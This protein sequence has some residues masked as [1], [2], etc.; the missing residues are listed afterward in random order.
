[1]YNMCS[2]QLFLLFV[3]MGVVI[4]CYDILVKQVLMIKVMSLM[5]ELIWKILGCLSKIN[6]INSDYEDFLLGTLRMSFYLSPFY[7]VYQLSVIIF[8]FYG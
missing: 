5:Q 3:I 1:M 2:L 8:G 6:L 7:N 4:G